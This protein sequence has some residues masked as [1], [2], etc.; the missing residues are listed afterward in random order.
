M[1]VRNRLRA[2][3][4]VSLIPVGQPCTL[5]YDQ[6][7]NLHKVYKDY[8]FESKLDISIDQ[9]VKVPGVVNNITLKGGTTRVIGCLFVGN[10]LSS[11]GPLP[12]CAEDEILNKL[13]DHPESA[14][15][16]AAH[17]TSLAAEF[18]GVQPVKMW[19][20]ANGFTQVPGFLMPNTQDA[21][22][23]Y[24][25][26][27]NACA[28]EPNLEFPHFM[29]LFVYNNN[30]INI[31]HTSISQYI[32]KSVNR[33][34]LSSGI[35]QADLDTSIKDKKLVYPY[36]N[37]IKFNIQ[38]G[39]K[40][41]LDEIDNILIS[42]TPDGCELLLPRV[43]CPNCHKVIE[44]KFDQVLMCDNIECTSRL[45]PRSIH[46]LKTLDLPI[47][48]FDK[49]SEYVKAESIQTLIDVLALKEYKDSKLEIP[50]SKAIRA[51]WTSSDD[52]NIASTISRFCNHCKQNK[53]TALYYLNNTDKI[54][55]DLQMSP[56]DASIIAGWF[57]NDQGLKTVRELEDL[58]SLDN[59]K[60][61]QD[62]KLFDGAPLFHNKV[63]AIT[64]DFI[65]G[66]K[67]YICDIIR[68]YQGEAVIDEGTGIDILVIGGQLSNIDGETVRLARLN[69]VPIYEEP[70]FFA[71]FDIDTDLRMNL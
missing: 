59:I 33:R 40:I 35:W 42:Y 63:V 16:Y 8:T 37:V 24:D 2:G 36:F 51:I 49:F 66:P 67:G 13:K 4:F 64:G 48:S 20:K 45:Y 46:L 53:D 30:G 68:S 29:D 39:T 34:I 32:I 54:A 52:S 71:H 41:L 57:N 19:L 28:H 21:N 38:K 11:E 14:I 17:V 58:L 44:V 25:C 65:H 1:F 70:E 27:V 56:E 7:G 61:I 10:D 50:L 60:I 6:H 23:F 12:E 31:I 55:S 69:R 15:F 9:L 26:V 22:A 62:D 43:E 5:E 18:L 47:L 3:E